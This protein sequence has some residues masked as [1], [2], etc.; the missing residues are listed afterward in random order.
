MTPRNRMLLLV[1]G[2]TTLVALGVHQPWQG[3][4]HARTSAQVAPVF[5]GLGDTRDSLVRIEIESGEKSVSLLR[6]EKG[7]VVEERF[8][9]SADAG[10]LSG[11]LDGLEDLDTRDLVAERRESHAL[12]GVGEG[13]GTRVRL[14]GPEGALVGETP[15]TRGRCS[16]KIRKSYTFEIYNIF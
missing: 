16:F 2:F 10:R 9:H 1:L 8:G 15:K 13:Q 5:P 6:G 4:A 3:D 14:F 7:W 11:L 12:Y